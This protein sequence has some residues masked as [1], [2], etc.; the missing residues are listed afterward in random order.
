MRSI[1]VDPLRPA[2]AAHE[3]HGGIVGG[4]RPILAVERVLE[5]ALRQ[6]SCVKNKKYVDHVYYDQPTKPL[7]QRAYARQ[8]YELAFM[9]KF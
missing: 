5:S 7:L 2:D 9:V 6:L 4:Y 8:F 3:P 1:D